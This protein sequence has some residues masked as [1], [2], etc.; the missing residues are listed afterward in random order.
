MN[1]WWEA[2]AWWVLLACRRSLKGY[3]YERYQR[4]S[5]DEAVLETAPTTTC[6]TARATVAAAH[7]G[8]SRVNGGRRGRLSA[9]PPSSSPPYSLAA[10]PVCAILSQGGRCAGGAPPGPL[11][12]W[13]SS[14]G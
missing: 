14:T 2:H 13:T 8:A 6:V 4:P 11:I 12:P 7:R 3:E 9:R 10:H 5:R 1:G